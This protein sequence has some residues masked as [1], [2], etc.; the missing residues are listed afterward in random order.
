L[1]L[2]LV[3]S[4]GQGFAGLLGVAR[5]GP[6]TSKAL[7]GVLDRADA[8]VIPSLAENSPS[9]AYEAASRGVV[10]IVRN[11]AGLPEVV[12]NLGMGYVIDTAADLL[13]LMVDGKRLQRKTAA[14]TKKLQ[15][16]AARTQPARVAQ[17]YLDL[18]K[19]LL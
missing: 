3:G 1:S 7:I 5:T 4:G 13:A 16:A 6:L 9:V 8:I 10:P 11:A 14:K 18:Y 17:S 19:D 15:A 12:K 2:V